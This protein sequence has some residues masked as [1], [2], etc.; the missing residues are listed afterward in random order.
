MKWIKVVIAGSLLVST[1]TFSAEWLASYNNDEMRG[2]ATKFLQTESDN[3][4][5]FDF[6]YNGGSKMT[7][8]LRSPKT[9][10]KGEQKA[11]DLKPNE[12]ML[13]ISK[14]QFSCNSYDGC[15]VSVKFDN[16]KIQKYKMSP[17]ENGRSDVIFFDKSNSFIKS[18][19]NHKKLIIEA[20]FYQAGPKQFKFNLEGYSTPKQG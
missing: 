19:S 1:T 2:T 16:E 9:E 20:D 5:D 13:L 11:E 14:G 10:L 8:V 15:D 3:A 6:P 12:A 17:A 7:L 4:V 18:I